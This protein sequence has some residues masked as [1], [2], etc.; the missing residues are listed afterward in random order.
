MSK[1][2]HCCIAAMRVSTLTWNMKK[3]R[4]CK[5]GEGEVRGICAGL[6]HLTLSSVQ[7]LLVL[8][9]LPQR[10]TRHNCCDKTKATRKKQGGQCH[11]EVA[12]VD[13]PQ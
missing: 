13:L 5:P 3:Y 2:W 6:Y 7:R 10:V 12:C 1:L 8:F 11:P 4:D 9:G